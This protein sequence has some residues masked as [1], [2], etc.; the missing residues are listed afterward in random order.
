MSLFH[1]KPDTECELTTFVGRTQKSGPDDVPAV[2][3]RLLLKSVPNQVLDLF[4]TTFR[5]TAYMAVEGQEQ[6]PGVEDTTP[7]LRSK[8]LKHWAPETRLEGWNVIIARGISEDTALQMGSCK[9]DDFKF[10]LY[11]GGHVDVDFRISTADVDEEGAGMLWGR[12][13]QK[14]FATIIAPE[15]PEKK[16]EAIDGTTGHPGA[17]GTERSAEDL[18]AEGGAGPGD[19][20]GDGSEGGET[21]AAPREPE[22]SEANWPFPTSGEGADSP[23]TTSTR[24]AR[25]RERMKKALAEGAHS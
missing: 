3:I 10:D 17:S 7:I 4:S 15:V 12:Q 16:P 1:L 11:E 20:A 19:G 23:P 13:K 21:D 25:G 5:H 22:R 14:V 8:D 2:S 6:L 18:F 24:T 9:L